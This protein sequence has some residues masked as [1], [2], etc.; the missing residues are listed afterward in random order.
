MLPLTLRQVAGVAMLAHGA[1]AYQLR[2]GES[3]WAK[4]PVRVHLDVRPGVEGG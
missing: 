4:G 3:T 2:G 1:A